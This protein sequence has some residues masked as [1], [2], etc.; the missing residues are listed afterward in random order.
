MTS[1][2]FE[3]KLLQLNLKKSDFVEL[4]KVKKGTVYNWGTSRIIKEHKEIIAVP[5]WV[6]PF[7]NH[8]EK[9]RK[10]DEILRL[11]ER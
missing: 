8:Y 7:L 2:E 4:A 11:L 6:E 9:S 1:E 3:A 5:E 10:Y